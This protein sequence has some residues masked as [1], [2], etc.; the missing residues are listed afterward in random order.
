MKVK[1]RYYNL[2]ADY[3][4]RKTEERFLEDGATCYSLVRVLSEENESFRRLAFTD[5]GKISH[6]LRIFR[7][8][9]MIVDA[10]IRLADQDEI[11]MFPA[12][13]GGCYS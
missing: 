12:V 10:N 3:L 9:Q 5:E 1:V 7:N 11:Q 8:G 13:S 2:V 6:R 4:G